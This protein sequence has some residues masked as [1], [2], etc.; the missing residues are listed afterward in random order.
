LL[1][2]AAIWKF[3]SRSFMLLIIETTTYG[4]RVKE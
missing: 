2:K 3:G 1:I 4:K